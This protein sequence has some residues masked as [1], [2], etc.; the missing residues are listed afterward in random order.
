M[1]P[2]SE[3]KK[4]EQSSQIEQEGGEIGILGQIL[5]APTPFLILLEGRRP[6]GWWW[7]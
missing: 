1:E 3:S 7:K 6:R 4:Q 2:L 5:P